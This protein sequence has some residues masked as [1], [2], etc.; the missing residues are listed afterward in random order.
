MVHVSC[1]HWSFIQLRQGDLSSIHVSTCQA[2]CWSPGRSGN[3]NF[4]GPHSKWKFYLKWLQFGSFLQSTLC[5]HAHSYI[6]T[7]KK[8]DETIFK[9][10]AVGANEIAQRLRT[11]N[12]CCP[13]Y[14]C[15]GFSAQ[16][17]IVASQPFFF[18]FGFSR[19]GFSV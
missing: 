10:L 1:S 11:L 4:I 3:L 12:T 9:Y 14:K 17:H 7:I 6:H 15:P 16:H 8:Y 2:G 18:F 19:Q 5:G 13:L